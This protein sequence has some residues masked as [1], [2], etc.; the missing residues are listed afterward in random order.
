M[1]TEL[2]FKEYHLQYIASGGF[3]SIYSAL[4]KQPGT[5]HLTLKILRQSLLQKQAQLDRFEEEL[6]I[7]KS[8]QH[9]SLPELVHYGSVDELPYLAYKHIKG[10]TVL[11]LLQKGH[12][13]GGSILQIAIDVMTQLLETLDYLHNMSDPIVHSDVSPEN[14]IIDQ[15]AR[16][17][18]ID[19]GC[20]RI[21]DSGQQGMA[22]WIG[23]PS[24][25]SPEQAQGL[26]WDHRSDLFQAG[27]VFYELLT[28]RKKNSGK[29]ERLARTIAANPPQPN[30]DSIPASLNNFITKLL[31]IE[32]ALRWQ[33]ASEC[34]SELG[35]I[36]ANNKFLSINS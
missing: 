35:K 15:H 23:K 1:N 17:F 26:N 22:K 18:L 12:G 6:S 8:L 10:R 5:P 27:I 9:S 25:L 33:S 32:P 3:A 21:L 24:Y 16:L 7:L 28:R 2:D 36:G 19:F 30:L 11:A 29:T 20:A 34:I 31:S 13:S 4:P 14:L